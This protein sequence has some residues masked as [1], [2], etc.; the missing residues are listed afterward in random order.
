MHEVVIDW[1]TY[2]NDSLHTN[3]LAIFEY[4]QIGRYYWIFAVIFADQVGPFWSC[5]KIVDLILYL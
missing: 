5:Y 1:L 3:F 4:D 2:A